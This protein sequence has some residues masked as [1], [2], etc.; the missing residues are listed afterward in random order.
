MSENKQ[1]AVFV[2]IIALIVEL[3]SIAFVSNEEWLLCYTGII[4]LVWI[5]SVATCTIREY[6]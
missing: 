2:T 1:V 3:L 5:L 4:F 6:E